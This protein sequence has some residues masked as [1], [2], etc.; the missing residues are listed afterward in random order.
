MGFN[1]GSQFNL[2]L[3]ATSAV[4]IT[5]TGT[6]QEVVGAL[7]G[8]GY[9]YNVTGIYTAGVL[10]ISMNLTGYI[11][12]YYDNSGDIQATAIQVINDQIHS[13]WGLGGGVSQVFHFDVTDSVSGSKETP[14]SGV[15]QQLKQAFNFSSGQ[16][17]TLVL[18]GAGALLLLAVIKK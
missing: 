18:V 10:D 13:N 5:P 9:F 2:N 6:V 7:N 11:S 17:M 12:D 16:T 15:L 3:S 8:S 14:T 4:S 1:P